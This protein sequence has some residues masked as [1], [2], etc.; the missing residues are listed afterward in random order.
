MHKISKISQLYHSIETQI[1]SLRNL[2]I[3]SNSDGNLLVPL[4]VSKIPEEMRLIVARNLEKNE[5]NID[6]LLCKFKS[7]LEARERCNTMTECSSSKPLENRAR[8]RSKFPHSSSAL[9]T[10]RE[11]SSVPYCIYCSKQRTSASCPIA[12]DTAVCRAIKE[13]KENAFYA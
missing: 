7:E 6:P 9:L 4:I 3:D 5:W 2:G 12:T 13:K 8:L 10:N 11:P 1:R